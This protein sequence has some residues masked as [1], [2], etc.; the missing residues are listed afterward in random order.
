MDDFLVLTDFF[1]DAKLGCDGEDLSSS[2]IR[3]GVVVE[4]ACDEQVERSKDLEVS[5]ES[6]GLPVSYFAAQLKSSSASSSTPK[7]TVG[8]RLAV[9]W[10]D[11]DKFYPGVVKNFN[12]DGA[13]LVVYDDG[14]EETLNLSEEKFNI[15]LSEGVYEQNME[16]GG[17][18]EENKRGEATVLLYLTSLL[19]TGNIKLTSLQTYLSAIN[20]YHE[21]LGLAGPGKGRAVTWAVKGMATIQAEEAAHEE[22]IVTQRTSLPTRHVLDVVVLCRLH[23]VRAAEVHAEELGALL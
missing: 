18:Y 15:L 4:T 2:E 23:C 8:T 20:N 11:D 5:D 3:H 16:R 22:N 7:V 12:E 19:E 6:E 10:K 21:D 17:D 14:D 9:Y 13:A 1:E